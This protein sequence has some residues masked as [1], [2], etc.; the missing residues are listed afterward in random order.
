VNTAQARAITRLLGG[1][2]AS[3]DAAQLA[4]AEQLLVGWA[5]ELDLTWATFRGFAG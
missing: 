1:L 3:L 2:K 4:R 5:G